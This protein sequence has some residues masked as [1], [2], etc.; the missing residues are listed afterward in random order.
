[1]LEDGIFVKEEWLKDSHN[2]GI[3]VRFLQASFKGWI[4]CRD[5]Q[6]DCVSFVLEQQP[7]LGKAHQT[8]QMN[9]INK[10]I[11]PSPNAIGIMDTHLWQQTAD[12]ALKSGVLSQPAETA[13]F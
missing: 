6:D 11:W 8:W 9:E 7:Q 13:A 10:L 12:I 5:H 4:F 1:M 3:A 2:Q